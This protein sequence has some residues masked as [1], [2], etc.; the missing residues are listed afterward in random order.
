[1]KNVLAVLL[2]GLCLFAAYFNLSAPYTW[3]QPPSR[4]DQA[5][6]AERD[7]ACSRLKH[8]RFCSVELWRP[9]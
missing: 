2:C 7:G 5:V 9:G 1:M 6:K 3:K 4:S 8:L